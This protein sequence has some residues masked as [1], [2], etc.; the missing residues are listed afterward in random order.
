ML[1]AMVVA[2]FFLLCR[3]AATWSERCPI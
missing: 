1:L 2:P 3:Q